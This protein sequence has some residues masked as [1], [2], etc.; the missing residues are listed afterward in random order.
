MI[1]NEWR[2]ICVSVPPGPVFHAEFDSVA[3]VLLKILAQTDVCAK[4]APIVVK[5]DKGINIYYDNTKI[6]KKSNW[7]ASVLT[8]YI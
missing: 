2:R 1:H 3:Y 5:S 8:L 7:N 6:E 4:L